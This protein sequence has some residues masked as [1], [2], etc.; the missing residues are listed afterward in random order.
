MSLLRALLRPDYDENPERSKISHAANILQIGE[1]QLLQLAYKEC[2]NEEMTPE[3]CDLVFR[4]Y[5]MQGRI[6]AWAKSFAERV[7]DHDERGVLNPMHPHFHQFDR[8]FRTSVPKG[9]RHFTMVSLA[10]AAFLIGAVWISQMAV[11]GRVTTWFP[12]YFEEDEQGNLR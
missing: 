4:Y 9:V 3:Q 6:P 2:Y 7:I 8:D 10:L 1:F 12:P 11:E 5:M